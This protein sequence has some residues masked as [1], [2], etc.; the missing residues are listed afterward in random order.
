MKKNLVGKEK[1]VR[2]IDADDILRSMKQFRDIREKDME[3]T[4]S[5]GTGCSWDDA[6][7]IIKRTSTVDAVPVRH[8]RW[9][10]AKYPLFTCSECGATYQD[11]GY[12][13]NFCPNCGADMRPKETD[14]N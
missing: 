3:M 8:G 14:C 11:N 5:R 2:L 10:E 6:V 9:I 12:G 4:G 7:T 1:R 13:Y